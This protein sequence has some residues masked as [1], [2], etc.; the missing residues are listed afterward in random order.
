MS[1]QRVLEG[2][3]WRYA[4]K[5][6]DPQAQVS[7]EDWFALTEAFRLTPSS[8]GVQPWKLID[9]VSPDIREALAAAAPLNTTKILT[10]SRLALLANLRRISAEHLESYFANM[11]AARGLARDQ[12]DGFAAMVASEIDA[13][14]EAEQANWALSQTYIALGF[15]ASAAALMRID[16]CPMEGIDRPAFDQILGLSGSEY[17]CAVGVAVGYRAADDPL[18]SLPRVRFDRDA[19]IVTV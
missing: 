1:G 16:M 9:V 13:K 7:D 3:R 2:L 4:A 5:A 19:V 11:A 8:Y 10:C 15:M 6:F 18:Q 14:E 12:I 17:T